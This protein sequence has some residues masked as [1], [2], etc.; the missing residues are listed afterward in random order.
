MAT[1]VTSIC[2]ITR[3]LEKTVSIL[4]TE[5]FNVTLKFRD[6]L[7]WFGKLS[8]TV[9]DKLQSLL[10]LSK[11]YTCNNDLK[12]FIN[13]I[14]ILW[15][16]VKKQVCRR[17]SKIQMSSRVQ[18]GVPLSLLLDKIKKEKSLIRESLH[19]YESKYVADNCEQLARCYTLLNEIENLLTNLERCDD[20][21]QHYL[22]ISKLIPFLMKLESTIDTYVSTITLLPI[23]KSNR[24]ELDVLINVAK[25]LTGELLGSEFVDPHRVLTDNA[26][27]KPVFIIK[28]KPK[29]GRYFTD[30]NHGNGIEDVQNHMSRV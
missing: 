5:S 10:Y 19:I 9:T 26:P 6:K 16:S 17:Y 25:L 21:L 14:D 18:S 11:S 15:T 1:N 29:I 23:N 27:K 4:K 3:I 8:C 24:S 13:E 2:E 12:Q 22:A 28:T 7:E 30:T 20:E